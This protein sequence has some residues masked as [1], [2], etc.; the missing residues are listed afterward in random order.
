MNQASARKCL[1]EAL[2]FPH[3]VLYTWRIDCSF[4][5]CFVNWLLRM[6]SY[7]PCSNLFFKLTCAVVSRWLNFL[8]LQPTWAP[9]CVDIWWYTSVYWG[10]KKTCLHEFIH[11]KICKKY[12]YFITISSHYDTKRKTTFYSQMH[13]LPALRLQ[14]KCFWSLFL[15]LPLLYKYGNKIL[16]QYEL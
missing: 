7:A 14:L 3:P 6:R 13:Q 2:C 4:H 11:I 8:C 1:V 15:P 10:E 5:K 9:I 12:M 16:K